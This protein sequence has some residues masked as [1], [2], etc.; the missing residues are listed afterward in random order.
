MDWKR[1]LIGKWNWKKPFISLGSI[2][3]MLLLTSCFFADQLIF[4]PPSP[5]YTSSY[6]D[7]GLL[8][9][10]RGESIAYVHLPADKGMP[11]IL[12]SHGNA[13]DLAQSEIIYEELHARGLGVMAYDYPGYGQSTGTP[14]EESCQRAIQAAWNHLADTGI[15]PSSIIIVGRSV[16]SGPSVWLASREK[17]AGLALISPFRSAFTAA[18]PTPVSIFPGDRFPNMGR[19][20]SMHHPLLIIHGEDDR[21]INVSHGKKLFAASPATDKKLH[22]IP[23]AG[24]NDLFNIAG[25]EIVDLVGKF[26]ERVAK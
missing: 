1:I 3:F 22:L 7:L 16:G 17:P 5:S 2:Y 26:A 23:D 20:R 9:S 18:I 6:P 12:Y 15:P 10:T 19:I 4:V 25:E 24:H 8:K 21:V 11:T 14:S 13:E